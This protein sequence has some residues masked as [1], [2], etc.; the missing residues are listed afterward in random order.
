MVFDAQKNSCI[1][2]DKV[3]SFSILYEDIQYK[4][5][6]YREPF[7]QFSWE[8]PEIFLCI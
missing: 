2:W 3:A 8:F 5:Q 1:E 7:Q 4:E 6:K